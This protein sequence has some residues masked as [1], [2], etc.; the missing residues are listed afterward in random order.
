MSKSG[1]RIQWNEVEKRR[2]IEQGFFLL[3]NHDQFAGKP[4]VLLKEAQKTLDRSRW[5]S[6][7]AS[8]PD[9]FKDGLLE[10]KK[11]KYKPIEPPPPL[12][13]NPP[14]EELGTSILF[15]ELTKRLAPS[16]KAFISEAISEGLKELVSQVHSRP[17]LEQSQSQAARGPD[18]PPFVNNRAVLPKI[19]IIGA[20]PTWI[21][22]LYNDYK[23][24]FS[25]TFVSS[26]DAAKNP[27]VTAK[28]R[29][30][31]FVLVLT[32]YCKHG[33]ID[34]VHRTAGA[35]LVRID[36]A[37]TTLKAKLDEIHLNGTTTTGTLDYAN[38][39]APR[40]P[41]SN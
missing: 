10:L 15:E 14:L 17:P 39:T 8:A 20:F 18:S 37:L 25:L 6:C 4:C 9:W 19:L 35:K 3:N 40:F 34:S 28:A 30:M 13:Q 27:S 38:H 33:I 36:G 7:L 32:H 24:I 5:R 12:L 31:D 26:Q 1:T 22:D 21:N 2:I 41:H 11:A 29:S 16:L 23:G